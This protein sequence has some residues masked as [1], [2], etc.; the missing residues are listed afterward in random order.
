LY[1]TVEVAEN[2]PKHDTKR[3]RKVSNNAAFVRHLRH[4]IKAVFRSC[5]ELKMVRVSLTR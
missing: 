5:Q 3:V 4:T 1:I 2:M